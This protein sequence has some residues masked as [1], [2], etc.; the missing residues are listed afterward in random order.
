MTNHTHDKMCNACYQYQYR[1]HRPRPLH[2][3]DINLNHPNLRDYIDK[4]RRK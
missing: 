2:N 4:C 1:T 3:N